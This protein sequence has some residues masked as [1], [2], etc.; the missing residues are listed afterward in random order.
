MSVDSSAA[1]AA[2][3]AAAAAG[4]VSPE[5]MALWQQ[6]Q[7]LVQQKMQ[8]E[9]LRASVAQISAQLVALSP[10]TPATLTPGRVSYP[11]FDGFGS[12]QTSPAASLNGM[13]GPE[14]AT[15]ALPS[16][17]GAGFYPAVA[18]RQQ[19]QAQLQSQGSAMGG[20]STTAAAAAA[21]L[22]GNSGWPYNGSAQGSTA[23]GTQTQAMMSR[24][25]S[26]GAPLNG[27]S[28]ME[29][30]ACRHF[31]TQVWYQRASREPQHVRT[32]AI[33]VRA[34]S[35]ASTGWRSSMQRWAQ[36]LTMPT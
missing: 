23:D 20:P 17:V 1:T 4:A 6:E 29:I 26:S 3:A 19:Q 12:G 27:I 11:G 16:A 9:A 2:A 15:S 30:G 10:G 34:C 35:A 18:P 8:M 22:A 33:A 32:A 5:A 24:S 13:A 28:N 7:M 31:A 25:K 36:V 21:A 14:Y